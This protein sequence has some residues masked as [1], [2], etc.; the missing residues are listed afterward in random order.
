MHRNTVYK[1][2]FV[3]A[4]PYGL[5]MLLLKSDSLE[6]VH[7]DI[8]FTDLCC[9]GKL[10]SSCVNHSALG[11]RCEHCIEKTCTRKV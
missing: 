3:I 9:L 10:V 2:S 8:V 4:F 5:D 1:N 6:Y 7:D 11:E